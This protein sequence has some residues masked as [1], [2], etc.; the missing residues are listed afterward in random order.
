M[1]QIQKLDAFFDELFGDCIVRHFASTSAVGWLSAISKTPAAA[2]FSGV[3]N[4]DVVL[5]SLPPWLSG[6]QFDFDYKNGDRVARHTS[7]FLGEFQHVH[8]LVDQEGAAQLQALLYKKIEITGDEIAVTRPGGG[9]FFWV[10]PI[11]PIWMG[12]DEKDFLHTEISAACRRNK[13]LNYLPC[14]SIKPN[15]IQ[16]VN[17]FYNQRRNE[18][19]NQ[20]SGNFG[21][22][23]AG[24]SGFMGETAKKS[25]E[26]ARASGKL[27]KIGEEQSTQKAREPA[28]KGG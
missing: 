12:I 14:H 3:L 16:K 6:R 13:K 7:P 23:A 26:K 25:L 11:A 19:G 10:D 28:K 15:R 27:P 5:A 9:S 24:V 4:M 21:A 17:F 1:I 8:L 20:M 22:A 18:M 2:A